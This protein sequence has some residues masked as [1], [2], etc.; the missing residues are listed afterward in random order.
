MAKFS[1]V[2]LDGRNV[3]VEAIGFSVAKVKAAYKRMVDGA[4][5]Y[6]ELTSDDKK[7]SD[8]TRELRCL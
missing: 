5:R 4:K 8:A 1:I 2:F 7:S 3:D 6:T